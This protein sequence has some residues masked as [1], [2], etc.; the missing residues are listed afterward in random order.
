[1]LEMENFLVAASPFAFILLL[2]RRSNLFQKTI[3]ALVCFWPVLRAPTD[4][5]LDRLLS[6]PYCHS[7]STLFSIESARLQ[8]LLICFGIASTPFVFLSD[9][10]DCSISKFR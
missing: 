6:L 1:M 7:R 5:E 10:G 3:S 9:G 8:R 2:D 4:L